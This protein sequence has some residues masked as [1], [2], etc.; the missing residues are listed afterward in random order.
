MP[1]KPR[2]KVVETAKPS[3][4]LLEAVKF[5]GMACNDVGPV[6][7]RHIYLGGNWAAASNGVIT[8]AAPI[9]EDILACPYIGFLLEALQR[10]N[11]F[12]L[13]KK[14]NSLQFVANKFKANIPCVDFAL[15]P[16]PSPD[17]PV[18]EINNNLI[19]ALEIAGTLIDDNGQEIIDVSMLLNGRSI[20]SSNRAI[21]FEC[22]HGLDLPTGLSLPKA[23]INPLSKSKKKLSK[24]GGSQSSLTFYFEDQSW[25]KTQL[26]NKEWPSVNF[27]LD[28]PSDP[29]PLPAGLWEGLAAIAPFST[30]GV[31]HFQK[32][33]I[34][35]SP[36]ENVG[37]SYEVPGLPDGL[38]FG[39]KQLNLIKPHIKTIDFQPE[40]SMFFGE[41]IRGALAGRR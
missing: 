15:I 33:R 37:A 17:E 32:G 11:E 24:I 8:I 40:I 19:N 7:E 1:R 2:S 31:C 13:H 39:I 18:A 36:S 20:I 3:T 29:K 28:R 23:I 9:K 22:W 41:N 30:D 5:V 12:E 35:S 26:F 6:N 14:E 16:I 38:S 27:L 25:I 34:Q 10:S 4:S 21:I